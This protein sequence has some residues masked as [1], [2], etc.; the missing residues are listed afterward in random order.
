[1][2][3]S[4]NIRVAGSYVPSTNAVELKRLDSISS[5]PRWVLVVESELYPV[6]GRASSTVQR[7]TPGHRTRTAGIR[8][9]VFS[10]W[11]RN[12]TSNAPAITRI[13]M[14]VVAIDS[15]R[16]PH[17]AVFVDSVVRDDECS[18]VPSAIGSAGTGSK[19]CLFGIG[20]I[21]A[22]AACTRN[23]HDSGERT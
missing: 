15:V 23:V 19:V 21:V 2:N 12:R 7:R 11:C 3:H 16:A 1:V 6:K 8:A 9:G 17:G 14:P 13:S 18:S 5:A 22:P 10:T 4:R 20:V